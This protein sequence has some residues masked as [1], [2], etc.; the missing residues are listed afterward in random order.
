[1]SRVIE[2]N[3]MRFDD[4]VL[5]VEAVVED[6]ALVRSQTMEDPPEWGPALCRGTWHMDSEALIPATDAQ[7]FEMLSDNIDDWAL[8]DTSDYYA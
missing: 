4:D 3:E 8:V 6:A 5:V 2:I 7:F 1:M